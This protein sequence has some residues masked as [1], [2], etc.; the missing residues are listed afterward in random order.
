MTEEDKCDIATYVADVAEWLGHPS[1]SVSKSKDYDRVDIDIS[2]WLYEDR[3]RFVDILA[4]RLGKKGWPVDVWL[5]SC[6]DINAH[7]AYKEEE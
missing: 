6:D 4:Q 2:D 7:V 1:P 3:E 5:G